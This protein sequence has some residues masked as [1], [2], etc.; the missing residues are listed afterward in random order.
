MTQVPQQLEKAIQKLLDMGVDSP[1]IIDIVHAYLH[2][3]IPNHSPDGHKK[4]KNNAQNLIQVGKTLRKNRSLARAL[5]ENGDEK[6]ENGLKKIKLNIELLNDKL[7]NL[8]TQKSGNFTMQEAATLSRALRAVSE[9]AKN[10]IVIHK[11]IENSL[12]KKQF[13]KL[14]KAHKKGSIDQT[15]V[16]AAMQILGL[17]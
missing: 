15:A 4:Q 3:P 14:E 11:E 8:Q 2:K 12:K 7:L 6:N 1:T 9:A 5:T 17:C 10:D 16:Q 13:Q